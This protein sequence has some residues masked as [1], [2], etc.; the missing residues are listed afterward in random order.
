MAPLPGPDTPE[1]V[2]SYAESRYGE[3]HYGW[4]EL[5]SLRDG[6]WKYIR[7]TDPELYDLQRDPGERSNVLEAHPDT[8]ERLAARLDELLAQEAASFAMDLT[9]EDRAVLE[10]LGYV[11]DAAP[12]A[13][14]GEARPDPKRMLRVQKL[15]FDAMESLAAN[16]NAEALR[17]LQAALGRDPNNPEVHRLFGMTHVAAGRLEPALD[18]LLRA[19]ELADEGDDAVRLEKAGVLM[20]LERYDEAAVE[21]E[22]LVARDPGNTDSWYNLGVAR[23]AQ[24]RIPEARENWKQALE[25]D[26]FNREAVD[27]MR[28]TPAPKAEIEQKPVADSKP[29]ETP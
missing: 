7:T 26:P 22:E 14:D 18:S 24:G 29:G 6:P 2:L 3:I 25:L 17:R 15:L 20:R 28:R 23:H 12:A 9:D 10:S 4:S 1:G 8:A 5:R 27:A 16:R 11:T 21:F 19:E 13:V